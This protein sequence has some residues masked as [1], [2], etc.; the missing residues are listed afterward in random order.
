MSLRWKVALA[1]A[2][3]AALTTLAVGVASYRSTRARL[4]DEIDRSLV[5]DAPRPF[6]GPNIHVDGDGGQVDVNL[7]G[8]FS[9]V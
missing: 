7:G 1:V 3:V 2:A 4:Y 5:V 6:D 8:P 9:P